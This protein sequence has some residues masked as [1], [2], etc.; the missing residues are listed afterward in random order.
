MRTTK[1]KTV[2]GLLPAV[3]VAASVL[4]AGLAG[5]VVGVYINSAP[6]MGY[7]VAFEPS[8]APVEDKNVRLVVS[9]LDQVECVLDLN[10]IRQFGGSLFVENEVGPDASG[11][12]VHWA[13]QRTTED[14]EDCG[15]DTNFIVRRHDLDL[16]ATVAGGYITAGDRFAAFKVDTGG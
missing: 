1:R 12:R 4:G 14:A 10:V 11:Y 15:K 16:L 2:G 8:P 5:N 13:G 3:I 7:I 6:Q 9:R